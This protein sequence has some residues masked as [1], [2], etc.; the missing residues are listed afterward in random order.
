MVAGT[1]CRGTKVFFFNYFFFFKI[2]EMTMC[3]LAG[4]NNPVE[5]KRSDGAGE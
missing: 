3:S 4:G 1:G 5:K 2:R